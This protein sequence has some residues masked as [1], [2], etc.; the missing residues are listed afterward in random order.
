MQ[1]NTH[2][3]RLSDGC[4]ACLNKMVEDQ[5]LLIRTLYKQLEYL[6]DRD[7]KAANEAKFKFSI[8]E[9]ASC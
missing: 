7:P 5:G 1:C 8:L 4:L 9:G 6:S 3:P 2:Y